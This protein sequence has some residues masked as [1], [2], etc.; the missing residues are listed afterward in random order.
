MDADE[1]LL[2]VV[3]PCA[4]ETLHLGLE[5]LVRDVADMPAS[6]MDRE[7]DLGELR[8]PQ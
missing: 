1:L 3:V 6:H 4:R 2:E 7:E 8:L 5:L